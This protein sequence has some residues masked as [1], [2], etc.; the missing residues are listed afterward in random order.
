MQMRI[1]KNRHV[2]VMLPGLLGAA[3]THIPVTMLRLI[4][5]TKS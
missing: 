4:E 2:V 3:F 1:E 5:D